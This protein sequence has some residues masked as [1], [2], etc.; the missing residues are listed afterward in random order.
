MSVIEKPDPVRA[1]S[2]VLVR[3]GAGG[4]CGTDVAI[5][6]WHE[7]VV[8]QYAP[9]VPVV[10]EH[11]FSGTVAEAPSGSALKRGDVVAINPQ[12]AC[13]RCRCCGLG[14]PTLCDDRR[15]MGG[16]IDGGWTEMVSVPEKQVYRLPDG[17]DTAV[18]PLLEPM[19]VAVHAV[20]E[21]VPVRAGDMV[22]VIG[23]GP[24]G[25]LAGILARHAGA[26]DVLITGVTA[27]RARLAL[28]RSLG[29]IAVD[30]AELD[31]V[32]ALRKVA[33]A[34]ADVVYETSGN[35]TVLEQTLSLAGKAGRIGLIG[36]CHGPSSFVTT[37]AVLKEL[38]LIGS[39]GYNDPTWR[40]VMQLLPQVAPT[41]MKLVT[42]ELPFEEFERALGL[43][44]R[45]EGVKIILR[46]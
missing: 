40:L 39:R 25:L 19:A 26:S 44:E 34:G 45:R 2:D 35:A 18:A 28:A 23:A 7:A 36:L 11:E 6:K 21:R 38:E 31:P 27:D 5:W 13:G 33:P 30:V 37:P 32:S 14:R 46:P 8:G 3:I 1:E 22:A 10:V 43:V 16:H 15:L 29:M 12:L 17:I 9:V 20:F 41:I 4:I 24:I 42:H